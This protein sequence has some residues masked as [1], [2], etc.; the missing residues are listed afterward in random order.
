MGE[1]GEY[2]KAIAD[3]NQALT[4]D[5]K[6]ADAYYNRGN[7][8]EKRAN[9]TRPSPTTTRPSRSIRMTPIPA[10]RWLGC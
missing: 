4:I 2:D 1:K 7:A 5:P 9:T 6:D 10:M 8:W 3:Y